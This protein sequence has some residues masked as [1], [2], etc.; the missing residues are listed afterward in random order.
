MTRTDLRPLSA[1]AKAFWLTYMLTLGAA[2][3]VL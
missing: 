1:A 2:L 3:W